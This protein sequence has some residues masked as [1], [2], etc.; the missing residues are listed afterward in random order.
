MK[1]QMLGL[2]VVASLAGLAGTAAVAAECAA[3]TRNLFA[4]RNCGFAKDIEGWTGVH[5]KS[6]SHES[7]D[8]DPAK[9]ALAGTDHQGSLRLQAP[10][11]AVKPDTEYRI[12]VRL[13]IASGDLYVCGYTVY[14]A[15]DAACENAS[16][17]LVADARP[18][19]KG[20]QQMTGETRTGATAKSVQLR[21]ECSGEKG[22]RVLFD[23]V[24][25]AE[26]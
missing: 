20:W 19:E 22:F 26:K 11:M 7:S 1:I 9:G 17:P 4:N 5:E 12:A 21:L 10:C 6:A 16:D 3:D 25:F 2:G 18:P 8:G 23:D 13:R 14:Q 15:D 24:V